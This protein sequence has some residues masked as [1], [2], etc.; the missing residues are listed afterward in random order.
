MPHQFLKPCYPSP[1]LLCSRRQQQQ[2]LLLLLILRTTVVIIVLLD[3]GAAP[4]HSPACHFGLSRPFSFSRE[5]HCSSLCFLSQLLILITDNWPCCMTISCHFNDAS[6]ILAC[7]L[8]P[9]SQSPLILRQPSIA[10]NSRL[11]LFDWKIWQAPRTTCNC[12]ESNG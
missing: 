2:L 5:V 4:P 10:A 11:P 12:R 1:L 8:F 7:L 9:H 6:L 3:R